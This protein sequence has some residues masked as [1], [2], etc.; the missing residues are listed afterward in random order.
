MVCFKA[1]ALDYNTKTNDFVFMH[2]NKY[3]NLRHQCMRIAHNLIEVVT[4]SWLPR[5]LFS[6]RL[7]TICNPRPFFT[8][9]NSAREWTVCHDLFQTLDIKVCTVLMRAKL[10][11]LSTVRCGCLVSGSW[12]SWSSTDSQTGLKIPWTAAFIA[13]FTQQ[14]ESCVLNHWTNTQAL[15]IIFICI[16]FPGKLFLCNAT[17]FMKSCTRHVIYKHFN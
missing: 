4:L 10:D 15:C 14:Q 17:Y 2:K 9:N 6:V 16:H 3:I 8:I 5:S 1:I 12:W 13:Y 11:L 7:L